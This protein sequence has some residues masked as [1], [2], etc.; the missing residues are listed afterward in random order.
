M[1]INLKI[2]RNT[3]EISVRDIP[4]YSG[5]TIVSFK[6]FLVSSENRKYDDAMMTVY[7]TDSDASV[8]KELGYAI[9]E[10][11][12][13]DVVIYRV[14]LGIHDVI[15]GRVFL[16]YPF[17]DRRFY[18]ESSTD[19]VT[20]GG[21]H[22]YKVL[23]SDKH[24]VSKGDYDSC[25]YASITI[26]NSDGDELAEVTDWF[27]EEGEYDK[28]Y[29][30]TSSISAPERGFYLVLNFDPII[31]NDAKDI[32]GEE[33]Y[34]GDWHFYSEENENV[35]TRFIYDNPT[36]NVPIGISSDTDYIGLR[37]NENVD[38]YYK[39][40]TKD[41]IP[42]FINTEKTKYIPYIYSG[43]SK[44]DAGF[45]VD[46]LNGPASKIEFYLHFRNRAKELVSSE[47][48]GTPIY[49]GMPTE[50]WCVE[51]EDTISLN[52]GEEYIKFW[53]NFE[54]Y[55]EITETN[56]KLFIGDFIG[57]LGF[58]D[59]DVLNRKKK[60]KQSF[61]RLSFYS[62]NNPLQT[63]MLFTSTIFFDVNKLYS[64]YIKIYTSKDYDAIMSDYSKSE[65]SG[66]SYDNNWG[67][68]L[69]DGKPV[70]D[71]TY[72]YS[73]DELLTAELDVTSENEHTSSA[74]GF[75]LY[76]FSDDSPKEDEERTIYMK[77]EFNHAG[78][79]RKFPMIL[80]PTK[81]GVPIPLTRENFYDYLY[82]PV[83]VSYDA[84]NNKYFYYIKGAKNDTDNNVIKLAL[85]EP[86]VEPL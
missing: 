28:V 53:N 56:D 48:D 69:F 42:D 62:S 11:S 37:Q 82:I 77:V 72:S 66:D 59:N 1:K 79:G 2:K 34:P 20:K 60:I 33:L 26:L 24:G 9:I 15:N 25:H 51:T 21:K 71:G 7:T 43:T 5:R 40:L 12:F 76:L 80:W 61:I 55:H 41:I 38:D 81:D 70:V 64:K 50:S 58:T 27:V 29:I 13:N 8:L 16:R 68:V 45:D 6:K 83:V 74:E 84:K 39:K 57:N 31:Y 49:G 32:E 54:N 65:E 14:K 86:K 17:I 22:Y 35:K 10:K 3:K 4:V 19:Y 78:Y 30:N 47:V 46:E 23:L 73:S 44:N 75:N 63:S 85:F 18:V 67:L 52:K 36:I